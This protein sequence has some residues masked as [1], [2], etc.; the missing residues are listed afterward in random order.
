MAN[1]WPAAHLGIVHPT[2]FISD[3][4]LP[5]QQLVGSALYVCCKSFRTS[6]GQVNSDQAGPYTVQV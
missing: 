3:W 4:H 5:D 6:N 2:Y 1:V